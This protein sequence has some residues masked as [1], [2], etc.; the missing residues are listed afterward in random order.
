MCAHNEERYIKKALESIFSQTIKPDKVIVIVD[1]C[2]DRTEEIARE[3][4]V[5]IIK[6]EGKK[7]NNSYAENLEIARQHV[8]SEF[9]AIVDADVVLAPNYFETLLAEIREDDACIS[10]EIVTRSKTVLGKLVSLWEKSYV[11]STSRR[12]R[13]CALLVRKS[14]LDKIGGFIDVPAPDTYMQDMALKLGYKIRI[15]RNSIAYHTRE[16][17]L[18]KAIK[19]QFSAGIARYVQGKGLARTFLHSIIRLRPFV[20]IGYFYGFLTR[21]K[22]P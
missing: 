3:F 11:I 12:P 13:G 1:R 9:Y 7:W 21:K 10:G 19:T 14:L 15:T 16:I 2:I 5:K 22:K 17:T 8:D 20:I 18:K 4:P 6:K